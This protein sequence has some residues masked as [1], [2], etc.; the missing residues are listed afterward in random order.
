M[1]RGSKKKFDDGTTLADIEKYR[2]STNTLSVVS[3]VALGV[4]LSGV[5]LAFVVDGGAPVPTL[6]FRF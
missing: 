3:G 1:S 6:G 2:D 4:G 5:T